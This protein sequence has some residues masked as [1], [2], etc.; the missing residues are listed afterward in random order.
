MLGDDIADYLSSGGLGTVGSAIFIG[1]L[2]QDPDNALSVVETGGAPPLRTMG[3]SPTSKSTPNAKAE[4][5]RFQVLVRNTRYDVGRALIGDAFILLDGLAD[6]L[7]NGVRYHH[8]AAVQ[9]PASLGRDRNERF[10][11]ACNFDVV[12]NVSTST[13]N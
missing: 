5:P 6:R 8:I 7:I 9:S 11:F 3:A 1:G 13:S 4:R 2:D 10:L 12:K